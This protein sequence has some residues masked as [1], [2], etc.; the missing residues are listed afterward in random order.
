MQK[1]QKKKKKKVIPI[2]CLLSTAVYLRNGADHD[3]WDPY[4][5]RTG[6]FFNTSK[7]AG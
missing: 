6:A 2:I 1:R 7:M 5:T 3:G 4:L